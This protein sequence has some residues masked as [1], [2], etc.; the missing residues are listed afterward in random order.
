MLVARR[1][2][3]LSFALLVLLGIG[4]VPRPAHA[5]IKAG[6]RLKK[7]ASANADRVLQDVEYILPNDTVDGDDDMRRLLSDP[8]KPPPPALYCH[9]PLFSLYVFLWY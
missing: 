8:S 4:T 6:R 9:R 3:T 2:L 5:A 1:S 7:K